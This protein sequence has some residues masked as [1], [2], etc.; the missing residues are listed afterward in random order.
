MQNIF[1]VD[2][3][4]KLIPL[5]SSFL[6]TLGGGVL[7]GFLTKDFT[8]IYETITKP[9]LSPPGYIFGIVW[10]ILYILMS[11]SLY[12]VYM[13]LKIKN[14]SSSSI[15]LYIIQ[16]AINFLWPIIFFM[17]RLYGLSWIILL[18]LIVILIIVIFKFYKIDKL[19]GSLLIPYLIWC[20][21]ALYLNISIWMLNE[22]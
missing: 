12:R 5:I 7:I 14:K 9:K 15:L 17:S 6:I 13:K 21:Y 19:S 3:K 10:P 18:I 22:M 16:L 2:G 8:N 1:K 20:I 11:I 4:F